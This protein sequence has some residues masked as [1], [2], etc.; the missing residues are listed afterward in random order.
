MTEHLGGPETDEQVLLRHHRYVAAARSGILRDSDREYRA[1]IFKAV[2][3]P[4]GVGVGS[5]NFWD[6]QWEGERGYER[7]GAV[8]PACQ[9]LGECSGVGGT[10]ESVWQCR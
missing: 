2:L 4:R 1:F 8:V 10:R 6:R 9:W 3:E 5:L 7:G